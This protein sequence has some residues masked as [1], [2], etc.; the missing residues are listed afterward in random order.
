MDLVNP[1]YLKSSSAREARGRIL[2]AGVYRGLRPSSGERWR[3]RPSSGARGPP[4]RGWGLA[5]GQ[6]R[7]EIRGTKAG[8]GLLPP[9]QLSLHLLKLGKE[10]INFFVCHYYLLPTS[11]KSTG[12]GSAVAGLGLAPKGLLLLPKPLSWAESEGAWSVGRLGIHSG[13]NIIITCQ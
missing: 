1:R 12:L 4:P 7:V 8:L 9:R 5:S 11:S 10:T 3:L 13:H 2:R 6:Q